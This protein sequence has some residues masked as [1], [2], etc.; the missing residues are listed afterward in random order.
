MVFNR[1]SISEYVRSTIKDKL[2]NLTNETA[3]NVLKVSLR[4]LE[5]AIVEIL[6]E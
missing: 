4:I 5:T 2:I 3:C 1:T 6:S